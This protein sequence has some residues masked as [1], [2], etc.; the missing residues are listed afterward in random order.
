M[1][2][3]VYHNEQTELKCL[4]THA[5]V[6]SSASRVRRRVGGTLDPSLADDPFSCLL[7][8]FCFEWTSNIY[9]LCNCCNSFVSDCDV[10]S[11]DDAT[12]NAGGSVVNHGFVVE[13]ECS[14]ATHSSL[15]TVDLTRECNN[16]N[17]SPTLTAEPIQCYER[18]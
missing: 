10:T 8:K 17:L 6:P 2:L 18:E 13:Y 4:T 15:S 12:T 7:S 9:Y 16:G 5:I 1:S 14:S 3:L 11:V